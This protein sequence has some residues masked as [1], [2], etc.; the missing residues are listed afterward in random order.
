MIFIGVDPGK[1]GGFAILRGEA[2]KASPWE[3]G[4]FIKEMRRLVQEDEQCFACVEKVGAMPNQGVTSM[5][6]F[7]KSAGFIEGVLSALDIPY[8]LV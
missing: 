8:I 3:D 1:Q 2:A 5:F 6:H 4:G 7:G